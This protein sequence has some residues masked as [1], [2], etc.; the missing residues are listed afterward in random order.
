MELDRI[1]L[2][3]NQFFGINHMSEGKAQ[4]Q[5]ERFRSIDA[6]IRAIDTAYENGVH[7]FMF[8]AHDRVTDLCDHFRAHPGKYADLRLYPAIPYA[9]KYANAVNEKGMIRAAHELLFSGR[10]ARHTLATLLRGGRSIIGGDV[11]EM[12]RLLVDT[13]IRMFQGLNVRAIFLQNIATDLLLGLKSKT[14]MVEFA[15]HVKSTYGVDP[16]F[17]T[18]NL[19]RLV[20]FLLDCGIENPIVCSAINKI[21]YFMHPDARSCERAIAT[22]HFRPMAMSILASGA[23][24]AKEAVEYIAGLGVQSVVFGA[25]SKSHIEETIALL[26]AAFHLNDQGETHGDKQ[27][28]GNGCGA[29]V[30]NTCP[31][32]FAS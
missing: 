16:A 30:R 10:T 12:M 2:G 7:A 4:E 21:G 1:I 15:G 26:A 3:D 17:I 14:V 13:E 11:I 5:T 28:Q 18:M 23:V 20:T 24:S 9:H 6:I 27:E 29:S 19:P 32:S 22:Q 25:S 8:T 31:Q